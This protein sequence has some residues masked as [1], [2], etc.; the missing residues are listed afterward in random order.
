MHVFV[1]L[2]FSVA[3]HQGFGEDGLSEPFLEFWGQL[4]E[5]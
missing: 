4:L 3:H 5:E 1:E 2:G